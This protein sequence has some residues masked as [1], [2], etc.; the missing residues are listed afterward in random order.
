MP[1]QPYVDNK[2]KKSSRSLEGGKYSIRDNKRNLRTT[3]TRQNMQKCD[4]FEAWKVY[5]QRGIPYHTP[6]KSLT[7]LP[8]WS[9]A[10]RGT[11]RFAAK[12]GCYEEFSTYLMRFKVHSVKK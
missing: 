8:L 4:L 12:E 3:A 11:P 7:G 5:P 1:L 2:E 6:S 9:D 10:M